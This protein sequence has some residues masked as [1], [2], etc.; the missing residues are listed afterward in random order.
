[1][2]NMKVVNTDT[3]SF[4]RRLTKKCL[5]TAERDKKRKYLDSCLQQRQ[6][7][8]MF[9]VSVDSLL[10]VEPKAMLKRLDIRLAMKWKN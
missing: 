9:V 8:P 4:Q 5:V 1:M 6:N 3:K 2:L 10:G 7:V